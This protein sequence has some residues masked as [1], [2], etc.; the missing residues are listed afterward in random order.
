MNRSFFNFANFDIIHLHFY[1]GLLFAISLL[2]NITLFCHFFSTYTIFNKK[3]TLY[4]I[5]NLNSNWLR[6]RIIYEIQ[7]M[8]KFNHIYIYI[9][10]YI[11]MIKKLTWVGLRRPER[12]RRLGFGVGME[13]GDHNILLYAIFL[14]GLQNKSYWTQ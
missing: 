13:G 8:T 10:I 6:L 11:Y 1:K 5:L 3:K 2:L 4:N 9:Y 14:F 12:Q 7:W